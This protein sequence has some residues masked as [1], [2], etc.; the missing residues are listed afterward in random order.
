MSSGRFQ[1]WLFGKWGP[2][3][4]KLIEDDA[5]WIPFCVG[6]HLWCL[7]DRVE[8]FTPHWAGFSDFYAADVDLK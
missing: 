2:L 1:S 8:S 4:K 7:G 3:E 5:A 6:L